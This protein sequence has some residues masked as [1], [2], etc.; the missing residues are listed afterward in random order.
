MSGVA[1][2]VLAFAVASLL[3]SLPF[4]LWWG[5]LFGGIDI[6]EHG[7]KNLG[8]ANVFRTLGPKHGIAVL[9]LDAAKGAA[10]V[11][12][13]RYLSGSEL[14]AIF[15]V[16]FAVLGHIFSPWVAFR[17]GKGVAAGLG[18]WLLLAPVATGIALA[19]FALILALSRRVS[20]GSL[21]AALALIP[22]VWFLSAEEALPVRTGLAVLTAGLVWLRHRSNLI[23]LAHGEEPPLWGKKT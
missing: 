7:S 11:I 19:V 10:A 21:A 9:L 17:G 2:T 16:L 13:A 5:R 23:R 3:G 6:R 8:A 12:A 14:V 18:G 1:A 22:L 20:I 15:A 4:G